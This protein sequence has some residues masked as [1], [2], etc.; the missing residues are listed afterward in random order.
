MLLSE[1]VDN[2]NIFDKCTVRSW[3]VF[4]KNLKIII[5]ASLFLI[6]LL[7]SIGMADPIETSPPDLNIQSEKDIKAKLKS[8]RIPF[9]KNEEQAD[10]NV[11]FY[12]KTFGGTVFITKEVEIV[13]A[14]TITRK[15]RR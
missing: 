9:I 2:S 10:N 3:D 7:Q 8:I 15:E 13:Y 11:S 4:M 5:L 12:A 14:I 6:V 1:I